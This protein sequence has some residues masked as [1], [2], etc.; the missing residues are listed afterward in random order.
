MRLMGFLALQKERYR[1]VRKDYAKL[2]K[3]VRNAFTF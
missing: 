1:K 3:V 2:A